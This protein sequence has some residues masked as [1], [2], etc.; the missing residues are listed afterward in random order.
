MLGIFNTDEFLY[1]IV[2]I[3]D[4]SVLRFISFILPI[5]NFILVDLSVFSRFIYMHIKYIYAELFYI[6]IIDSAWNIFCTQTF[7]YTKDYCFTVHR[8]MALCEVFS[9]CDTYWRFA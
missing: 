2:E 8:K 1:W 5:M 3:Y 4:K 7:L 6:K 9:A